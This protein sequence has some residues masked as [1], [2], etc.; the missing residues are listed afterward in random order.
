MINTPLKILIYSLS[1]VL[2]FILTGF[3]LLKARRSRL[4]YSFIAVQA[5]VFLWSLHSLVNEIFHYYAGIKYFHYYWMI[6][7]FDDLVC[8][9]AVYGIGLCWLV[10]CL[11]YTGKRIV[12]NRFFFMAL[13]TP[14][15][16]CY[17]IFLA[18]RY[19]HFN[20][21]DTGIF[22]TLLWILALTTYLYG[23][24]GTVGLV[25]YSVGQQG[26]AKKQSAL[27]ILAVLFPLVLRF[28]QDFSV[29]ALNN[30]QLMY[31]FDPT[32]L[33]FAIAMILIAAAIYKYKFMNVNTLALKKIIDNIKQSFL[34]VDE[35]NKV[36]NFNHTFDQTFALC[37][38]VRRDDDIG[39]LIAALRGNMADNAAHRQVLRAMADKTGMCLNEEITL[40]KDAL[41]KTYSVNIQLI[42]R[43]NHDIFGRIITFDDITSYKRL[44]QELDNTN[45]ELS[46]ANHELMSANIQLKMHAATIE[47]L[48]TVRERNRIAR[49]VHDTLGHTMTL[50]IT[51]MKV[52]SI[53]IEN[54][55]DMT[56]VN[57]QEALD[58]ARDGLN[59]LRRSISGL[60]PQKLDKGNVI[61][62][63]E[64]LIK[65]FKY[66]GLEIHFSVEGEG[67]Y[68]DSEISE[69]IFRV[70]QE[71]I[72]NAIRH[73]K[74]KNATIVVRFN[75]SGI[76]LFIVDDGVGCKEIKAGFGLSSMAE[77]L[78]RLGGEIEY[79]S[80]GENGFSVF[81]SIPLT[82]PPIF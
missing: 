33:G 25:R 4:L 11:H 38:K 17:V 6:V 65:A 48:T 28:I 46:L 20:F 76:K 43:S 59:E 24:L 37:A 44:A 13:L 40:G 35:F 3:L 74:A 2:T 52:S 53:T 49:D 36:V 32:P 42:Y 75:D 29:T 61:A 67:D 9:P 19:Y 39:I 27:L 81:A 66:S 73:G 69:I 50:L 63:L 55:L 64:D 58:I 31:D 57:I 56:R 18:L 16:V 7:L 70:C 71:A 5:M 82:L 22:G 8:A 62:A 47:E 45:A 34:I 14:T 12:T 15:V 41:Q 30:R 80:D 72:T 10:F 51:L 77:R 1:A 21:G 26:Y 60:A 79:G 78:K 23:V 54:D 68:C